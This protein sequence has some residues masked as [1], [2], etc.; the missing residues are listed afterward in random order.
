MPQAVRSNR[1]S[2]NLPDDQKRAVA[3]TLEALHDLLLPHL[4]DLGAAERHQLAK[5]GPMTVDFVASALEYARANP[6]YV[7]PYVDLDEFARDLAAV[8]WLHQVHASLEQVRDMVDDS[9]L[10][11]GSEAYGAAQACFKSFKAAAQLGLPG[12]D[13]IAK[14][15]LALHPSSPAR[16]RPPAAKAEGAGGAGGAPAP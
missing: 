3:G 11:S 6:Q 10:L 13:L 12:A 7:P 2:L 4:V 9:M 5:M 15:L 16:R 8:T 1:I 14:A